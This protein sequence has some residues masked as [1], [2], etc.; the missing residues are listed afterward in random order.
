MYL[1]LQIPLI[2]VVPSIMVDE[3]WYA[4]TAWNFSIENGFINTVPESKTTAGIDLF[5]YT[6]FL[7]TAFK[8]FDTS[9]Y[10]AKMVSIIGG[11]IGL[12][13]FINILKELRITN[14]FIVI[15]SSLLFIF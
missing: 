6:F 8:L 12:I 13:G 10:M 5:L 1:L 9:L 14:R 15:V 7:G 2:G 11:L 4:N 3:P